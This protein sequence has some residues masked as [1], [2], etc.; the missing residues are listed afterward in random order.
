MKQFSTL[1]KK[2][3]SE[4]AKTFR[5]YTMLAAFF[6][7]GVISPLFAKLM[8]DIFNSLE[9]TGFII[10]IPEPTA[11]DSWGQFFNN[12]SQMG[13][14]VLIIVFCGIM[15]NEL[16]RGTLIN[17]LTKGLR[18]HTVILAKFLTSSVL[19][20]ACYTL[21]LGVC[22]LYTAYFWETGEMPHAFLVFIAPW[23]FGEL[24][25][26]LMIFG[27]AVFGN[28]YGS[29]L[30]CLGAVIA[31]NLISI[32]PKAARYNPLTLSAGTL[33]LL[34]GT[35]ETSDF[36]IAISV[37]CVLTAA[38]TAGTVIVFNKKSV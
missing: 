10:T 36:F 34:A 37:C 22:Y 9:D 15:A 17:L 30:C 6:V 31:M 16:S 24:L 32:A 23:L 38:L 26:A 29:L 13:M 4:S 21:C 2:E 33:E 35:K 5:L 20:A 12:V 25:I 14:L 3:F 28:I 7:F 27:G 19:W 11:L 1:V 8:P 18:R